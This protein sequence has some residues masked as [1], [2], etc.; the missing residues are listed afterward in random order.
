MG[1]RP[2]SCY[3]G[4][5]GIMAAKTK[6]TA[7]RVGANR[8]RHIAEK[9]GGVSGGTHGKALK[10]VFVIAFAVAAG[11]AFFKYSPEIFVSASDAVKAG[12]RLHGN[13]KI[14]NCSKTVQASLM[15][16]L[17]SLI[18]ADSNS[19]DKEC[20]VK[21]AAAIPA[22]DNICVKKIRDRKNRSMA[23]EVKV[24][25]RKPVALV[26]DGRF[27]LVDSKGVRFGAVPG[28]YYDLPLLVVDGVKAGDTVNL[29][30]FNRV[31]KVSRLLGSAFFGQISQIDLSGG[32]AV[33]LIFKS[34]EAEY[35]VSPNDIEEKMAQIKML[36]EKLLEEGSEPA[37]IDMRYHRLAVVS[38]Q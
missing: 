34:G 10:A 13:V 28:Q 26:H 14:T 21:A 20:A 5:V 9:R 15:H 3:C 18:A 24:I 8:Q 16:A 27:S 29:D 36:R 32:N 4:R 2:E 22:I 30:V 33:N 17:D 38:A 6:M 37:K 11:I 31:K 1:N 25:E 35:I 19:F 23:T 12:K 7:K